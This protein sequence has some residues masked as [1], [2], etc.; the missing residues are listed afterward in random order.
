MINLTDDILIERFKTGD[1]S[2]FETLYHRYERLIFKMS[3]RK[4]VAGYE[5]ED[6]VQI[7][8][9]AFFKATYNFDK[10]REVTSFYAYVTSCIRN[11]FITEFRKADGSHVMSYEP[12][13]L[14][15][16]M[17][18]KACYHIDQNYKNKTE[19]QSN[20]K[21]IIKHLLHTKKELSGLERECLTLFIQGY[22]YKEIAQ[23]LDINVKRVDNALF[24][25]RKKAQQLKSV[26]QARTVNRV[27]TTP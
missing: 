21:R 4:Y 19:T 9:L 16:V 14:S 12:A 18:Q 5:F 11:A 8:S 6:F 27:R 23:T 15:V 25:C 26:E 7:A 22:D 17:E 24:R 2:A 13:W 20:M 10:Q 1:E 3:H